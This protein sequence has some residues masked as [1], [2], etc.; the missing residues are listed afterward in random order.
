[1]K[2]TVTFVLRQPYAF[3][4]GPAAAI[5]VGAVLSMLTE[6]TLLGALVL[7]RRQ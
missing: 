1:M 2:V 3:A 7:P 6:T 5:A 4:C